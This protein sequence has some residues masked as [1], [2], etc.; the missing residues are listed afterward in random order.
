MHKD[1]NPLVLAVGPLNGFF[2][3]ISKTAIVYKTKNGV[4][5]LYIGGDLSAKIKFSGIDALVLYGEAQ[6]NLII[7]IENDQVSFK[8]KQT[9]PDSLGL[10]GKR[11]TLIRYRNKVILDNYFETKGELLADV[12]KLMK[13]RA[14]VITGTKIYS[15]KEF[16]KYTKLYHELLQLNKEISVEK[17]FFPSCSGCPMGCERSKIGE[18]GGNILVHSLVACEHAKNIYSRIGIIFSC[19]NVIGYD[20]KHEDIENLEGLVNKTTNNLS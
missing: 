2:P 3:Y 7:N 6:K 12:F 16:N 13:I 9:D 8:Q 10:P 11:S 18:V 19:L 5:D 1:I 15:P 4:Q 14:M 17:G 20:Y